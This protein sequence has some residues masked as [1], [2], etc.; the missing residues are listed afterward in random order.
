VNKVASEGSKH[1][2][3]WI[4]EFF[5]AYLHLLIEFGLNKPF[6][7][8]TDREKLKEM[9]K[10]LISE[11]IKK[12]N[13][14]KMTTKNSINRQIEWLSFLYEIEKQIWNIDQE[15]VIQVANP[16]LIFYMIEICST[17]LINRDPEK[18]DLSHKQIRDNKKFLLLEIGNIGWDNLIFPLSAR[19]N[20]GGLKVSNDVQEIQNN[21][22]FKTFKSSSY[23]SNRKRFIYFCKH[24]KCNRKCEGKSKNTKRCKE[25]YLEERNDFFVY[26]FDSFYHYAESFRY[27]PVKPIIKKEK[28]VTFNLSTSWI[29]T[30]ILT[31]WECILCAVYKDEFIE[32]VRNNVNYQYFYEDF[33]IDRWNEFIKLYS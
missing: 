29:Y 3:R 11:Q 33:Q 12:L 14:A 6:P 30:L 26:F 17:I 7:N 24:W 10:G 27:R 16:I 8:L 15:K 23:G 9:Q 2:F 13:N 19:W 1:R 22:Y 21:E 20:F 32:L 18:D 25:C 5:E 28:R 4:L 31:F